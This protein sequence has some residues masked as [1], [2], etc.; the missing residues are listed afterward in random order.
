MHEADADVRGVPQTC[1]G[2]CQRSNVE[3]VYALYI[4]YAA[5]R[6]SRSDLWNKIRLTFDPLSIAPKTQ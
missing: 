1:R 3:H 6:G 2:S 5:C 4:L